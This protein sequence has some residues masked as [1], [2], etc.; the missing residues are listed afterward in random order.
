MSDVRVLG[1]GASVPD[2][3]PLETPLVIGPGSVRRDRSPRTVEPA[4][5][6]TAS[7][8]PVTGAIHGVQG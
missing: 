5:G 1:T 8:C 2:P 3:K 7:S 4:A 6:D